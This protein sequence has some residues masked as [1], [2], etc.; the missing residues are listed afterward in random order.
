MH[1]WI[2]VLFFFFFCSAATPALGCDWLRH[3]GHLSNDSLVLV[4]QMGGQLTKQECPV[5]FPNNMYQRIKKA[6]VE[7]RLVFIRDSLEL[8]AGLYRHGNLSSVTWDTGK[9]EHFLI[10]IHRQIDG[11]N[12][13]VPTN[14]K[15]DSRLRRYY[16]K[17]ARNTLSEMGGSAASWELIRKETRMHLLRLDLLVASIRGPAA[18]SRGR[19]ALH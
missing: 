10:S 9:T 5:S 12:S 4:E 6:E 15:P 14:R 17:L 19:S 8:I 16:R 13:C 2:C 18:A 7:S 3:Y 11:L 1:N